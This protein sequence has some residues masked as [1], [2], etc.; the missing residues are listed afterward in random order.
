[1]RPWDV[2]YSPSSTLSFVWSYLLSFGNF[3]ACFWYFKKTLS[4]GGA[5]LN[6]LGQELHHDDIP[7]RTKT[8]TINPKFCRV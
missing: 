1:M 7:S 3:F 2:S 8:S 6:G 4:G 5:R